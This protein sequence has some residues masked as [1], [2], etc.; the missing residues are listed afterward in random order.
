[1]RKEFTVNIGGEIDFDSF[2]SKTPTKP[3]MIGIDQLNLDSNPYLSYSAFD[4]KIL[5]KEITEEELK[6]LLQ[7]NLSYVINSIVTDLHP[8]FKYLLNEKK[9]IR[10]MI[11]VVQDTTIM[12]DSDVVNLNRIMFDYVHSEFKDKSDTMPDVLELSL[13]LNKQAILP[14]QHENF[15]KSTIALLL[16][17]RFSSDNPAVS[18]MRFNNSLLCLSPE[19]CTV[20]A[21]VNIYNSYY[22]ISDIFNTMMFDVRTEFVD[23]D[24]KTIYK[25]MSIALIDV[26]ESQIPS[27]V[28]NT[29]LNYSATNMYGTTPVRFNLSEANLGPNTIEIIRFLGSR[30]IY[31]R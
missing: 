15:D 28:Y 22:N 25:N 7:S 31:V 13:L 9:F 12:K 23:D 21:L 16:L 10:A 4:A 26:L 2:I 24:M 19:K 18:V 17:A 27:E 14:L 3:K 20:K 8:K 29:L 5:D 6:N 30:G 1:M 11:D